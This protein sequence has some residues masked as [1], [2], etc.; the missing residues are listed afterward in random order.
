MPFDHQQFVDDF[1]VLNQAIK[2]ELG[3]KYQE[4]NQAIDIFLASGGTVYRGCKDKLFLYL[5]LANMLITED[6]TKYIF[7]EGAR[8]IPTIAK[9]SKNWDIIPQIKNYK[10]KINEMLRESNPNVD[11]TIFEILVAIKYIELGYAVEFIPEG[12]QKTPDLLIKKGNIFRHVECKKMQR[13]NLYSYK[14]V[15]SWYEIVDGVSRII[16]ENEI[17]GHFHFILKDETE[18]INPKRVFRKINKKLDVCRSINK[19]FYIVKNNDFKIKFTPID[20]SLLHVD[21]DPLRH[22]RGTTLVEYLIKQYNPHFQYRVICAADMMGVYVSNIKFAAIISCDFASYKGRLKKSQ[23]VKRKLFEASRQLANGKSGDI[24]ILVEECNGLH[25]YERRL[26]DNFK[27]ILTFDDKDG[28]IE[29]VYLHNVK[30]LVPL[31]GPFDV[32][33]TV[34]SF[35]RE[36]Y[37]PED[38]HSVW[39]PADTYEVGFGTLME[40]WD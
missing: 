18:D 31:D 3:E 4:R 17:L 15:D 23:H 1:A 20:T 32:E 12:A 11:A 25:V 35:N 9:L 39:Y 27:V 28:G 14:E 30:Y 22:I 10:N 34:I 19:S 38:I 6:Y 26:F 40:E 2:K 8:I 16:K 13:G 7:Q 37:I 36:G 5:S 29:R 24:H 33:E 21:L